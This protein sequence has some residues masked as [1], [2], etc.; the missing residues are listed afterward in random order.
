MNLSIVSRHLELTDAI[1]DRI[2]QSV[3]VLDK[4][5]LDILGIRAIA[6]SHER[7]GKLGHTIEFIVQLGGRD[8]VVIR[9]NDKDLYVAIDLAIER[10]KKA[11]R[12]HHD[13]IKDH[14][15]ERFVPDVIVLSHE[16][17]T[18]EIIQMELDSEK[19]M[20]I[21]EAKAHLLM[22][23]VVFYPFNDEEG[24]LRVIFRRKDGKIGVY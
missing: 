12:R 4:Y 15:V 9:Q 23:D 18:E 8:S 19:L 13:K 11:L 1:K 6:S 21:S 3:N 17:E 5:H 24:K 20:T 16:E 7:N 14:K 2:T 22:D 10:A